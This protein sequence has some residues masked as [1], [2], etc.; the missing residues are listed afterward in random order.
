MET[1]KQDTVVGN[2]LIAEFMGIPRCPICEEDCCGYQFGAGLIYKPEEM[3]YHTSW[4]W[5][6]PVVEKI[7]KI[8]DETDRE[9]KNFKHYQK[10]LSYPIYTPIETIW[11]AVV[12][13]ITWYN[14][15]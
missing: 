4:D 9:G 11:K 1:Q 13:F 7:R 15:H 5:L 14:N 2:R 12:Q 8:E 3:K 10:V 6:M